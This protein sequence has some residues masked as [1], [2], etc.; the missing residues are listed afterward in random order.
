MIEL[1]CAKCG[2]VMQGYT[3]EHA[4]YMLAQHNLSRTHTKKS[5]GLG[6]DDR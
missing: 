5:G 3:E 2:K 1:K 4:A 6:G